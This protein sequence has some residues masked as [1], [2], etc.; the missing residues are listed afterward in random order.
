MSQQIGKSL[1]SHFRVRNVKGHWPHV[2]YQ[3]FAR[4][5]FYDARGDR[6]LRPVVNSAFHGSEVASLGMLSVDDRRGREQWS[7]EIILV[8]HVSSY[9]GSIVSNR[10]SSLTSK[11]TAPAPWVG[12][13]G[14]LRGYLAMSVAQMMLFLPLLLPAHAQSSEL[15]RASAV[16]TQANLYSTPEVLFRDPLPY[17]CSSIP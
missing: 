16:L 6:L 8:L 5:R 15:S 4:S 7:P 2:I 11:A 3:R 10:G 17:R 1:L 14:L 13:P 9:T 12:S